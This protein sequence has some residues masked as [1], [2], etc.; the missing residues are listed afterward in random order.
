[1]RQIA[2]FAGHPA[3]LGQALGERRGADLRRH[4]GGFAVR[5]AHET[6]FPERVAR[7]EVDVLQPADPVVHLMDPA[8]E[9]RLLG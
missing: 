5:P 2:L 8:G 4:V 3:G 9:G 7:V 6:A 1:M